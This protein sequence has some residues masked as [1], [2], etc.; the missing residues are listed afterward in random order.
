MLSTH[1]LEYLGTRQYIFHNAEAA[2]AF[3]VYYRGM[4]YRYYYRS[5]DGTETHAFTV[6]I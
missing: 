2:N 1:D 6:V 5:H 4:V 3:A